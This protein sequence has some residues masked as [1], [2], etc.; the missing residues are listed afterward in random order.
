MADDPD[1]PASTATSTRDAARRRRAPA[2]HLPASL[3]AHSVVY[4]VGTALQGLG[5][6]LVLPFATRA[7]GGGGVR[8]GRHRARRR[9][10]G[11]HA[12]RRRA[13][14]GDPARAPPRRR[15]AA[16]GP[17]ARR[18]DDPA[19]PRPRRS[20]GL[21]IALG[22]VC[23]RSRRPLAVGA[24]R[25]RERRAHHRRLGADPHA[26]PPAAVGLP[27]AR[28][29][30]DGGGAARGTAGGAGRADG[31][32]LPHGI[33][34]RRRRWLRSSRCSSAARCCPRPS[35]SACGRACGSPP[36]CCRRQPR[37]SA[38]SRATCC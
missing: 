7:A 33:R 17:G 10:D 29:A 32:D 22:L 21:A 1:P 38:C 16:R 34:R 36:R 23:R 14:A 15:G 11:R 27:R 25:A 20:L 8:P 30:L 12:R 2:G 26:G 9:A 35:A 18:H 28:R 31:W 5:V 19:R 6:L 24:A 3:G 37:C 13:A 4:L